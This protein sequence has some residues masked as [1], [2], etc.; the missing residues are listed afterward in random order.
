MSRYFEGCLVI[1]RLDAYIH[2]SIYTT[3]AALLFPLMTSHQA[4]PRNDI[5]NT[6]TS[7]MKTRIIAMTETPRMA[8]VYPFRPRSRSLDHHNHCGRLP[9]GT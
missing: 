7:M 9:N 5:A 1:C 2:I 8:L 3:S 6:A 4:C